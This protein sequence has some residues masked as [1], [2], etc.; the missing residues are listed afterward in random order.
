MPEVTVSVQNLAN[1]I[2]KL[3]KKQIEELSILISDQSKELSS[4]RNDVLENK[5]KTLKRDEVFDV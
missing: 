5:V 1:T 3:N 4:R 2:K